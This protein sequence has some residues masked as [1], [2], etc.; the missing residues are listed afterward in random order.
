MWSGEQDLAEITYTPLSENIQFINPMY[1]LKIPI[2]T[3]CASIYSYTQCSPKLDCDVH[4]LKFDNHMIV[5][6]SL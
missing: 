4:L 5:Q 3:Q 2:N 1:I 6:A